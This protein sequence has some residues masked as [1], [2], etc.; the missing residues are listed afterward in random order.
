MNDTRTQPLAVFVA[1][2]I[3]MMLASIRAR[4]LRGLKDLPMLWLVARRLRRFGREFAALM[5][6]FK[7]GTLPPPA[8]AP[9]PW[10][11]PP[12]Q[13]T[14]SAQP[15]EPPRPAARPDPA[16]R[17]RRRPA[18][19]PTVPAD[20]AE[21]DRPRAEPAPAMRRRAPA[22][23]H[24]APA[25]IPLPEPLAGVAATISEKAACASVDSCAHFVPLS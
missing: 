8:P 13:E 5:A 15:P 16:N 25:L 9:A 21:A 10:T 6:A 11:A 3:E 22:V 19:P 7:A 12:D 14:A 4:G 17:D 20:A 1:S 23:P 2:I 18:E 24:A